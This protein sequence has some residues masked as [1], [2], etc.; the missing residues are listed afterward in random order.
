MAKSVEKVALIDYDGVLSS[1]DTLRPKALERVVELIEQGFRV[2][3]ITGRGPQA[4]R[5]FTA[6]ID[7]RKLGHRISLFCEQ[8]C[9]ELRKQR[10]GSWKELVHP[11]LSA[12]VSGPRAEIRKLLLKAASEHSFSQA[13]SHDRVSLYFSARW[14]SVTASRIR[15]AL[16]PVINEWN[17]SG[18]KP[19][20]VGIRT[21][22]GLQVVPAAATKDFS[23]KRFL[24]RIK[25][26]F[27]GVAIGDTFLDRKMAASFKIWFLPV[28]N[29]SEF[30]AKTEN[31][32]GQLDARQE[33]L[34]AAL[35]KRNVQREK[36]KSPARK[37]VRRMR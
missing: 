17:A 6:A 12:Y 9:M 24:S 22:S 29:P 25:K 37:D 26:P 10:D 32:A 4:M 19:R 34:R 18:K 35:E 13:L 11:E 16:V 33:R 5:D 20:L 2:A 23:A 21:Q 27:A 7:A 8:G 31:L 15:K 3:I 14:A 1:K 36:K 28:K 30:I